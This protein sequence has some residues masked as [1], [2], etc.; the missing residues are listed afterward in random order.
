M[1]VVMNEPE[2]LMICYEGQGGTRCGRCIV[3]VVLAFVVNAGE[4]FHGGCLGFLFVW[5]RIGG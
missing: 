1:V 3:G 4:K 5:K 2:W